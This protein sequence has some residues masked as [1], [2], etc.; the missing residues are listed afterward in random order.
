[1]LKKID[2]DAMESICE[3]IDRSD[4]ITEIEIDICKIHDIINDVN[5]LIDCQKHNID[6]IENN[7][8][9]Q[10]DNVEISEQTLKQSWSKMKTKYLYSSG[11]V[12]GA[13]VGSLSG[14]GILAGVS[15][16]FTLSYITS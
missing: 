12:I 8:M 16:G 15:L 1:M 3:T 9:S 2:Q 11:I 14:V 6:H 10:K 4:K 7:I 5:N 13:V